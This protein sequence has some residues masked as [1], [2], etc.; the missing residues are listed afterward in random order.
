MMGG[1]STANATISGV[2]IQTSLGGG[3]SVAGLALVPFHSRPN[4]SSDVPARNDLRDKFMV[5]INLP[6]LARCRGREY[7][8]VRVRGYFLDYI[9]NSSIAGLLKELAR[10]M[11]TA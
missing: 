9:K 2:A 1:S 11:Q 10:A 7:V 8:V 4:V 5:K 6:I 3:A